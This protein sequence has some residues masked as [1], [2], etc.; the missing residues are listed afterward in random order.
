M[1]TC[2]WT[3]RLCIEG[4]KQPNGNLFQTSGSILGLRCLAFPSE[5]AI[6]VLQDAL[7]LFAFSLAGSYSASQGV[8]C[9][10][11]DVAAYIER[12]DGGVPAVPDNIYLTTGASDGIAVG[13]TLSLRT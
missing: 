9:I 7:M 2:F 1:T 6:L 11:E 3:G 8:N 13:F 4:K 10:R 12:R 5:V